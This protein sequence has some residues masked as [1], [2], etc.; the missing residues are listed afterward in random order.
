M[1]QYS[2]DVLRQR[3]VVEKRP[4]EATAEQILRADT[5]AGARAILASID[6]RRFEN[7]SEGQRLRKMLR[8]E[9]SLW[10]SGHHAVAGVDEAG[11]SPLAG[12][13]SA[14]AVILKPGTRIVGIDDSKKLDAAAREELAKE[15]KEK[16]ESWCVVF[17]QVEEID[18]INIYWAGIQ[19]MQRAVRGLR[20]TPQHLLIDAKRLKEIDIP[21]E[22][23][24]KGDAKS[25]SIAA[26]SILAKVERDA[27]M[28]TLDVRHPG[29]GFADH[30][31][32]PV[33]A[34]YE[35]LARFGA[36]AAHRRSFGPV[37]KA[38]GLPPLPPWP[39]ASERPAG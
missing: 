38:L 20:L 3:Y 6:R 22:A 10:E 17:V 12:P 7:R 28:R 35:A 31:G 15:I 8:F 13:V 23:I 30:K 1:S 19:A 27:V 29:Y 26:A 36:C 24:I 33:P 34:H 9:T 32:Y 14:G 39:S 18:A 11:M 4:L 37:R 21:Q 16:A 2:L 25:A 5:R